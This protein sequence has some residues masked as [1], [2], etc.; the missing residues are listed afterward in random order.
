MV[1]VLFITV[2]ANQYTQVLTEIQSEQIVKNLLLIGIELAMYYF[3]PSVI[4]VHP[5]GVL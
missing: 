5:Y 3:K 4:N 1:C 2:A